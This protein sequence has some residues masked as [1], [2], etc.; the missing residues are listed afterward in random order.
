MAATFVNGRKKFGFT[1][2]SGGDYTMGYRQDVMRG[3]SKGY[4]NNKH[5]YAKDEIDLNDM[6]RRMNETMDDYVQLYPKG[7]NQFVELE[8]KHISGFSG[9]TKDPFPVEAIYYQF[10]S[11]KDMLPDSR[12]ATAVG[13]INA[14]KFLMK[15]Q[16]EHPDWH[17]EI[18]MK[19]KI[20][21]IQA[22]Q[23]FN[24]NTEFNVYTDAFT[25]P[26]QKVDV[27]SSLFNDTGMTV[28]KDGILKYN[29]DYM[30]TNQINNKH[31]KID[32]M[33][34][35]RQGM[36]KYNYD[37][38]CDTKAVKEKERM[39]DP[40]SIYA[41]YNL[42]AKTPTFDLKPLRE[43]LKMNNVAFLKPVPNKQNSLQL[44]S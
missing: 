39:L 3:P 16:I 38:Y 5:T 13:G 8:T 22:G 23:T 6:S 30:S 2:A 37:N 10:S 36:Q 40:T 43:P 28:N 11:P 4:F 35:I 14:P 29:Y 12:K 27:S 1:N 34:M 21:D 19:N 41:T 44:R 24:K 9:N 25:H 15:Y 32:D 26:S 7:I 20:Q 31:Q 42:G 17:R 18:Q 33:Y